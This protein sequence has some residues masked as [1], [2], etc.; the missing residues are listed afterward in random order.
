LPDIKFLSDLTTL[1]PTFSLQA[2]LLNETLVDFDLE[3]IIDLLQIKFAVPLLNIDDSIGI[4]NVLNE[5]IDLFE[6]PNLFSNLF[7]LRGFNAQLGDSFVINLGGESTAPARLAAAS[8]ANP[9]VLAAIAGGVPVA[10][11]VLLL[12][13]GLGGLYALRRRVVRRRFCHPGAVCL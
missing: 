10:D 13:A 12:F 4:G 11:T 6:S 7:D 2:S 5:G 3:F 9:I 8:V 1:T